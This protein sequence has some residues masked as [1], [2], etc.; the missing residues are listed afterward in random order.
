MI[1]QFILGAFAYLLGGLAILLATIGAVICTACSDLI[2]QEAAT[3]L[4][5]LPI[6]L[7]EY[8]ARRLP[9]ECRDQILK[10]E[11]MPE[12]LYI[13]RQSQG[14]PI[15]NIYQGIRFSLSLIGN[16]ARRIG[17]ALEALRSREVTSRNLLTTTVSLNSVIIKFDD[18]L[19]VSLEEIFRINKIIRQ[20]NLENE[21]IP[22]WFNRPGVKELPYNLTGKIMRT[23]SASK[24]F[25]IEH[26]H[27]G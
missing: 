23:G 12:L 24:G 25:Y 11:W 6:W 20:G 16:P 2:K 21:K 14:L 19:N 27:R 18:G 17:Q 9:E 10:S 1:S 22:D 8:A 5:R 15:T 26:I 7:L 4:E 3:R 13:S